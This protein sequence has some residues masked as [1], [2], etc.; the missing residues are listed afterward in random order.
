M[1]L[2]SF[3]IKKSIFF[4]V[5]VSFWALRLFV[6]SARWT[7]TSTNVL[8]LS[9]Y[10]EMIRINAASIFTQMVNGHA[11]RNFIHIEFI[12]EPM[13]IFRYP[14]PRLKLDIKLSIAARG[15]G[16]RPYPACGGL[17][18]LRFEPL[19][20]RY[21][22]GA[23]SFHVGDYITKYYELQ[24]IAAPPRSRAALTNVCGFVRN[25]N[26]TYDILVI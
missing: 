8:F 9:N 4:I 14:A 22:F 5:G 6:I 12:G 19:N 2:I 3:F 21:W 26:L 18:Y 15:Y 17:D 7:I 11:V 24:Y 1:S 10:F 16:S 20:H 25:S 13:C 23:F